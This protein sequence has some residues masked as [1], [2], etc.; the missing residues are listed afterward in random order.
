MACAIGRITG[1]TNRCG[2]ELAGM[3]AEASLI[4]FA[5]RGAAEWKAAILQIVYGAGR[6][7][8]QYERRVLI[9][10]VVAALDGIEGMPLGSVFFHIAQRRANASLC[11]AGMASLGI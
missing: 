8:G 10:Q 11:R 7:I 4:N 6:I 5:F 1:S 9:N 2:A 3:A